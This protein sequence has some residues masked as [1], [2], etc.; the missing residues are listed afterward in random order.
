MKKLL[1]GM[2]LF[3][4]GSL[5]AAMLLAGSMANGWTLNGQSSALWNI[6][7]YGLLPVLYTFL[8]RSKD[9][10]CLRGLHLHGQTN[11][12]HPITFRQTINTSR[13]ADKCGCPFSVP[14]YYRYLGTC[15][16]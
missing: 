9:Q 13:A 6:S 7:R 14:S 4:S 11:R 2:M 10:R 12:R 16:I 1:F 3:C 15:F 5:S 8:I